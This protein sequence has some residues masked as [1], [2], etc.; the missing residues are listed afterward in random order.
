MTF[1]SCGVTTA[2]YES[3]S[4]NAMI[5]RKQLKQAFYSFE[6]ALVKNGV[7]EENQKELL[8][9]ITRL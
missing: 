5:I 7:S 4:G 6:F 3:Y 1:E 8:W 9:M 2:K